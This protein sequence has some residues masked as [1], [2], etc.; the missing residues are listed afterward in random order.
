MG[1]LS[2][3]RLKC[4][5]T[6]ANSTTQISNW[7]IKPMACSVAYI[8]FSPVNKSSCNIPWRERRLFVVGSLTANDGRYGH[9]LQPNVPVGS[10]SC[11][12]IEVL[13]IPIR[14]FTI[15]IYHLMSFRKY[16]SSR[17]HHVL[18]RKVWN[19]GS[20]ADFLLWPMR[21][22]FV[23]TEVYTFVL[24]WRSDLSEIQ[25]RPLPIIVNIQNTN[26]CRKSFVNFV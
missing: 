6:N 15:L 8:V 26:I 12:R 23:L 19:F 22:P 9:I 14:Y 25:Y 1:S 13:L 4:S 21:A 2:N 7:Y 11:S 3:D 18:L 16:S 20:Y 17:R 5:A 24:S 10:T